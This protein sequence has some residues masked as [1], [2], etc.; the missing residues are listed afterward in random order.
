M[1]LRTAPF[2][3]AACAMSLLLAGC[4]GASTDVGGDVDAK[5]DGR[6]TAEAAHRGR[7]LGRGPE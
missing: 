2:V 3:A 5:I 1:T 6:P 7:L 4:A